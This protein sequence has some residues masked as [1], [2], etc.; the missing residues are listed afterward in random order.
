[1]ALFMVLA[2]GRFSGCRRVAPRGGVCCSGPCFGRCTPCGWGSGCG[3]RAWCL[4]FGSWF[5]RCSQCAVT[6][7]GPAP[8]HWCRAAVCGCSSCSGY[9]PGG[10]GSGYAGVLWYLQFRLWRWRCS[11]YVVMGIGLVPV[12]VGVVSFPLLSS[13]P[14]SGPVVLAV[15]GLWSV[16]HWV[17]GIR[18][19]VSKARSPGATTGREVRHIQTYVAHL[20][21]W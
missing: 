11:R 9:S 14:P 13:P 15:P 3:D 7:W 19:D 2:P 8:G 4:W 6:G 1:M 12:P 18:S 21:V 20:R 16:R 17:V 5:G 10:A